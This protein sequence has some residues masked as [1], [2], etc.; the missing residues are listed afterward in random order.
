MCVCI[1]R[2]KEQTGINSTHE[3]CILARMGTDA[4]RILKQ[5][6]ILTWVIYVENNKTLE[7]GTYI[8]ENI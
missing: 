8:A 2:N 1:C 6:R 7:Q 5:L 3:S 4:A